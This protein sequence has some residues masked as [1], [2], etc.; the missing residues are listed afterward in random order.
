MNFSSSGVI[1]ERFNK[2]CSDLELKQKPSLD[3]KEIKGS[4]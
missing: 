3:I 4:A 1:I 2:F